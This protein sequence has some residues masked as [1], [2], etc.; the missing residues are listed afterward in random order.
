MEGQPRFGDVIAQWVARGL[1]D[2]A[3]P[4]LD[5]VEGAPLPDPAAYDGYVL[6]GSDKGVYDDAA[7]MAPLRAFLLSARASEKPLFGLCFGHQIMADTFGG[8]AEKVGPPQVG[9]R[10]F[11]ALGTPI[12]GHVW[13]QDQVTRRPPEAEVIADAPY[14]P[15]A[16]LRYSFPAMSVQ[17]H[18]EYSAAFITRFLSRGRGVHLNEAATDAALAE[19]AE[20][21]VPEDLYAEEMGAF[22]KAALAQA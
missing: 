1:P 3:L 8:A 18:P 2:A 13:H 20:S 14:C 17:F 16:G 9:V 22:F 10:A 12:R 21:D 15:I 6:S 11:T 7:W 5:I 19:L 4:V